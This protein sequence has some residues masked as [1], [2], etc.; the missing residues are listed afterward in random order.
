MRRK[1]IFGTFASTFMLGS[2]LGASAISHSDNQP[3][4]N[5]SN[6]ETEVEVKA[7]LEANKL[8]GHYELEEI[9]FENI[10]GTIEQVE[11][12]NNQQFEVQVKDRSN[13][14]HSLVIDAYTGMVLENTANPV[15]G[16]E[17]KH[18]DVD[19]GR[20][21]EQLF[22]LSTIEKIDAIELA[23][24]TVNGKA[25]SAELENRQ[26]EL[27]YYVKIDQEK[28]QYEVLVDATLGVVLDV[29]IAS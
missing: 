6:N 26:G 23:L 2:A 19:D 3:Q 24:E 14:V 15:H 4:I 7:M 9:V 25:T 5:M 8:L 20:S 18:I 29:R 27:V 28:E 1:L 12:N 13:R 11:L 16:R 10:S 17:I 21:Y 22:S